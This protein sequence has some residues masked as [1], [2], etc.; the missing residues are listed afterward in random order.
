MHNSNDLAEEP[1]GG[2]LGVVALGS[3]PI[4]EL[5]AGAEFHDQID[6][7]AVLVNA[8]ELN[9]VTVAGE[10]VHDLDL[11]ADVID[12]VLAAELAS[13][14]ALA[15]ELLAGGAVGDEVG[16]AELAAAELAA[17]DVGGP[18]ILHWAAKDAAVAAEQA[19]DS[20]CGG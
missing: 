18:D 13:G 11:A 2:P 14:D 4:E 8:F 19:G 5:A 9:D 17:D 6:R 1:G 20:V 12:V 15:G 16:D 7:L 10:V 3:D